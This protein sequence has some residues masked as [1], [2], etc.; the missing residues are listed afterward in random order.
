MTVKVKI[1]VLKM[2]PAVRVAPANSFVVVVTKDNI[3]TALGFTPISGIDK[4]DVEDA[5]GFTP[6]RS[7]D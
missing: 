1:N 5:L 4:Q 6:L 2:A 3:L 7:I